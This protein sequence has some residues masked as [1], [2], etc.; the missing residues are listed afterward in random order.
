MVS[1]VPFRT[2]Q[3]VNI[4]FYRMK[5]DHKKEKKLKPELKSPGGKFPDFTGRIL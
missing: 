3:T 2:R 1:R 5:I 4:S